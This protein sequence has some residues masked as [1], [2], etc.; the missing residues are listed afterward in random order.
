MKSIIRYIQDYYAETDKLAWLLITLF[1]ALFVFSNYHFKIDQWIGSRSSFA[2][3]F[4]SRYLISLTAF[5]IPYLLIIVLGKKDFLQH[6]VFILLLIVAPA[7]F[8]FKME[9]NTYMNLSPDFWINRYWNK[10]IYWPTLLVLTT[11]ILFICWRLFDR[12]QIFY[13]LKTSDINWTPYWTMLLIMLPLIVFASTQ[14][15]FLATYPKLRSVAGDSMASLPWWKK[16]LFEL[17]YG[18][19]FFTIELFFRG[20]L[21]LAFA[22]F[23]GKDAILPMACFYCT[24]HFGKPLAECISSYFGGMLLGIVVYKTQSIFGGLMVHLGIAWM[25]EIGGFV[26]GSW[27][28]K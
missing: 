5:V 3:R 27:K 9:F 20:F 14:A 10:V 24:I 22:K 13:G 16:V 4:F 1:T 2:T 6:P 7:I 15:D 19:D 28:S 26:G 21:I 18:T 17:S 12:Q 11:T 23:A 8:S 25:M